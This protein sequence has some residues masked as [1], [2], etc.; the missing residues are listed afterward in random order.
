M[1][2]D[3]PMQLDDPSMRRKK[4]AG[5]VAVFGFCVAGLVIYVF[6]QAGAAATIW[7]IVKSFG[8]GVILWLL[9]TFSLLIDK[10]P[11]ETYRVIP[12]RV[13][14]RLRMVARDF[15]RYRKA[16]PKYG[17]ILIVVF[18]AWL[19]VGLAL[20]KRAPDA[21]I[22]IAWF[23]AP[24]VLVAILVFVAW[25][26]F[27]GSVLES[28]FWLVIYRIGLPVRFGARKLG[29][30]GLG[31]VL[32]SLGVVMIGFSSYYELL[33]RDPGLTASA[34]AIM[35]GLGCVWLDKAGILCAALGGTYS[36]LAHLG[37]FANLAQDREH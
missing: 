16:I 35:E 7:E 37:F 28:I 10:D 22:T 29:V 12:G 18:A 34:R 30:R 11:L 21:G 2:P 17:A 4:R 24:L 3:K 32:E 36:L 20:F 26:V 27:A 13:Q 5:I 19:G 14:G 8:T 25:G 1:T 23:I 6:R 9:F 31:S 33:G 15:P